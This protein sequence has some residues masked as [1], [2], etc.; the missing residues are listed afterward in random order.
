MRIAGVD[1]RLLV[2]LAFD[3]G[4]PHVIEAERRARLAVHPF[5]LVAALIVG[6][7]IGRWK[8]F[9]EAFLRLEVHEQAGSGPAVDRDPPGHLADWRTGPTTRKRR[10]DQ[11]PAAHREPDL[12]QPESLSRHAHRCDCQLPVCRHP[13]CRRIA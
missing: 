11:H 2:S 7:S 6:C 1:L 13:D 8:S 9:G 5:R 12:L 4:D 3:R 10:K